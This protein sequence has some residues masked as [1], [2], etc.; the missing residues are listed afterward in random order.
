MKKFISLILICIMLTA[1]FPFA[2]N[3]A[4]S[5]FV[6]E[7]G[8]LLSYRGS[9]NEITLPSSVYAVADSAFEGNTTL[10]SV[11][12]PSSVD[13]IGDRAFYGCKSLKSV[14]GGANVSL[15]GEFAFNGTPYY[16]NSEEEFLMLGKTLLWYNGDDMY[17]TLPSCS[18]IAPYAFLRCNTAK[19]VRASSG[20]I[21][22][23]A[24]AFY[25]CASLESVDIPS[26]VSYI[27]AYAFDGTPFL[28]SLGEFP[29]LGDGILVKY[30]GNQT[31]VT[32]PDG[33]RRIGSHCFV[34][35]KLISVDIPESVFS[36]DPYAFADCVGLN[37]INFSDGL[38]TI[39]DGAFRGSRS[40]SSVATPASLKYLGQYSF[41]GSG[42]ND[43]RLLGSDLTV[44]DNAFNN[45]KEISYALISNGV[46]ALNS[47]AFSDCTSLSGIS[48]P[49]TSDVSFDAL[50]GCGSV[51]VTTPEN[52]KASSALSDH[53]I[54]T[55]IGDADPDGELNILD[56][57]CIQCFTADVLPL[58]GAQAAACDFDFNG[59]IDILDA[60]DVQMTLAELK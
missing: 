60:A 59:V 27:G 34:S 33:V 3:A 26:T 39:G 36:I 38:V 53:T 21:S 32:V 46:K 42:L 57:T 29:T 16:D 1:A 24:G 2:V 12:I 15:V 56:A 54:N 45:C 40:L 47:G 11:T 20:L 43:V 25:D 22:I 18:S 6:V 10:T 9:Y 52:S 4:D 48:V 7:N 13:E 17:I 14:K 19:M 51:T 58:G 50:S 35:S 37:E 8:I 41:S 31:H 44:S 5:D 49:A 28:S 55:V 23:G 30:N